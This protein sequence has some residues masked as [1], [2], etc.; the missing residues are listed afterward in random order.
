MA[1]SQAACDRNGP[2]PRSVFWAN[3]GANPLTGCG[4]LGLASEQ[5]HRAARVHRQQLTAFTAHSLRN[6]VT[7]VNGKD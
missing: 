5:E 4:I 2:N 3:N 1:G 7:S 6:D